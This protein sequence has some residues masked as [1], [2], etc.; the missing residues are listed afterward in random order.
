MTTESG[1]VAREVRRGS[2][3]GGI[4]Y[5]NCITI[6]TWSRENSDDKFRM[7]LLAIK[8]KHYSQRVPIFG[9]VV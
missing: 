5:E 1:G 4:C 8:T 2:A 9:T 7:C 6:V 3:P